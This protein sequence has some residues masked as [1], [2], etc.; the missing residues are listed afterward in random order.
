MGKY[1]NIVGKIELEIVEPCEEGQKKYWSMRDEECFICGTLG[2]NEDKVKDLIK[3]S[4]KDKNVPSKPVNRGGY[5][6]DNRDTCDGQCPNCMSF[7]RNTTP[8]S[9]KVNYCQDCGQAID[10]NV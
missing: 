6:E 9:K 1:E 10:W 5:P 7:V 4:N 2:I 3:I 8:R